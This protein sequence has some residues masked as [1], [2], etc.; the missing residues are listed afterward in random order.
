MAVTPRAARWQ[1]ER[2]AELF[3]FAIVVPLLMLMLAAIMDFGMMFRTFEAVTNAAR[4]GA[5]VGVLPGYANADV[6][7]RVDQYMVATGLTGTYTVGV[8]NVQVTTT[9]N[10][11]AAKQ[12]TVNYTYQPFILAPVSALF[13]G[14]FGAVPLQAVTV[15]RTE[16][17]AAT[18]P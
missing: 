1:S 14:S 10:T 18:G 3:E 12:V 16:A 5:R 7:S 13:G 6:T 8:A 2:G 4:E 9:A 17:Q 11:F 15:M